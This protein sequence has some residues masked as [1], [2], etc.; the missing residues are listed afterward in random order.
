[1]TTPETN[2]IVES[3][4]FCKG[5]TDNSLLTAILPKYEKI[6]EMIEIVRA[7][8][9]TTMGD[10][11]DEDDAKYF[12]KSCDELVSFLKGIV[13]QDD[14]KKNI[15]LMIF[16]GFI[17]NGSASKDDEK[18][19]AKVFHTFPIPQIDEYGNCDI[20]R[21]NRFNIKLLNANEWYTKEL[22]LI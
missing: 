6:E 11:D 13:F 7:Y 5:I 1:M 15:G 21:G 12:Y 2:K 10:Y 3:L 8:K 17:D 4:R 19:T 22:G 18:R 16:I 20:Y 9:F 14:D